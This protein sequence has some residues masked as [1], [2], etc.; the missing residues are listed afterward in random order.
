LSSFPAPIAVTAITVVA[1]ALLNSLRRRIRQSAA[2]MALAGLRGFARALT[3][4]LTPQLS[5]GRAA[6]GS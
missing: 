4:W 1:A 6:S 2:A 5:R 3:S